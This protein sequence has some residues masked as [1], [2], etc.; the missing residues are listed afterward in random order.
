M[1]KRKLKLPPLELVSD[2]TFGKRLARLR[3][4]RGFT[5]V[6]LAY[7]V[8][9]TQGLITDYEC[10]RLRL[11]AEMICRFCQALSVS[12]DILLGLIGATKAPAGQENAKL[13]LKLVRRLQKMEQ[14]PSTKQKALIQTIDMFLQASGLSG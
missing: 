10:N 4:E 3:K 13:S 12:S 5:Q 2:E 1:P 11:N 6:E 14:L 8:G 7:K 9:I